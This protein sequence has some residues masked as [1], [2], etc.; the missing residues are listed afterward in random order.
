MLESYL[1]P[2][3]SKHRGLAL[4]VWGEAGIGKSYTLARVLKNLPCRHLSLHAT[5]TLPAL[6][7]VLSKPKKLP[8]WAETTLEK[9]KRGEAVNSSDFIS[10]L[11]QSLSGLA[12][13]VLHL[14]DAHEATTERLGLLN[15]LAQ[16][17]QKL[18]GVGLLVTSRQEFGQPFRPIKLEPLSKEAS[19]K[20]LETELN[21]TLPKEALEFIYS[22]AAG[23]PL[24]TL[25]YLRF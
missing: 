16:S 25:E 22:K 10:A 20:L 21:A 24:F 9:I 11:S 6:G 1:K 19:D 18:K 15:D 12:P 17:V 13:F 23:N 5:T 8:F 14:E 4:G 3:L 7:S 2:V